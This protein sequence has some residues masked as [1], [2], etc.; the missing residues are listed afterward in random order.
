MAIVLDRLVRALGSWDIKSGRSGGKLRLAL[1]EALPFS[2][3]ILDLDRVF[4]F[5]L[6]LVDSSAVWQRLKL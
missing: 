1:R 4:G 6:G 5:D 3:E 2:T